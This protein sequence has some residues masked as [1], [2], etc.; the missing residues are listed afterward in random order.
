MGRQ[1]AAD[2]PGRIKNLNEVHNFV[3]F[4]E[5]ILPYGFAKVYMTA[6]RRW[7]FLEKNRRKK[8][9]AL[10]LNRVM[11]RFAVN[12][13]DV[14]T[15]GGGFMEDFH[16][17]PVIGIIDIIIREYAL[18]KELIS[19][20]SSFGL[21]TFRLCGAGFISGDL[22]NRIDMLHTLKQRR[23]AN[24]T[25]LRKPDGRPLLYDEAVKTLYD[26]EEAL[27]SRSNREKHPKQAIA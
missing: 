25:P 15:A 26:L 8:A 16:T 4:F 3:Q 27:I 23:E 20:G 10:L 5:F 17:M 18:Q 7:A 12:I 19:P 14:R 1:H 9:L 13:W 2:Y 24:L 22:K 11:R 6:N 21:A